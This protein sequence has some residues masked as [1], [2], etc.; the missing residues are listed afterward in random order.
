MMSEIKNQL[1]AEIYQD[2]RDAILNR[3][4]DKHSEQ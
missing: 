1:T 4:P 3:R 2:V